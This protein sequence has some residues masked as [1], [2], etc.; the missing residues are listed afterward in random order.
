MSEMP[1]NVAIS[2]GVS[3]LAGAIQFSSFSGL[4]NDGWFVGEEKYIL[5]IDDTSPPV[6][7]KLFLKIFKFFL[8]N[9]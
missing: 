3:T 2:F 1:S 8:R 9:R 7:Y 4:R 5:A 6:F